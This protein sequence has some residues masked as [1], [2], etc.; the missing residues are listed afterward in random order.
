M[1][2]PFNEEQKKRAI[3]IAIASA[4]IGFGLGFLIFGLMS[5]KKIAQL[6]AKIYKLEGWR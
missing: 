6:E 1:S 2:T 3:G 5:N 4:A